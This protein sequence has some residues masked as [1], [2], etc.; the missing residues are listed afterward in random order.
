MLYEPNTYQ[1]SSN[2]IFLDK[3]LLFNHRFKTSVQIQVINQ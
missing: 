1:L 2:N 3:F